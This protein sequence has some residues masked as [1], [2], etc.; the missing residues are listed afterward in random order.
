MGSFSTTTPAILRL[1]AWEEKERAANIAATGSPSPVPFRPLS[2]VAPY[3]HLGHDSQYGAGRRNGRTIRLIIL[4]TT[5]SDGFLNSM[6]Y[7]ARR[8]DQVSATCYSGK[9][10]ELGYTVSESDRPYTTKRWNDES[11][12]VEICGKAAYTTAQWRARPKQLASLTN[13]LFTWCQRWAV[14]AVWL[15][16]AEIAQGA[17]PH[18]ASPVQG[19]NYGIC[20]HLEANLAAILLGA[21]PKDYSH[22]DIGPGLRTIVINE[23]IPEVARRLGGSVPVPVPPDQPVSNPVPWESSMPARLIQCNDNDAAVFTTDGIHAT[24]SVSGELIDDGIGA[25]LLPPKVNGQLPIAKVNRRYLKALILLG[26]LPDYSQTPPSLP[27][28]TTAAHF[29]KHVP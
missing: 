11:I 18:G 14:P 27:G 13:L 29:K 23:I 9:D 6:S 10:G 26:P 20:D 7:G 22:V 24:S 4:H 2:P 21:A 28:R 19:V 15:W 16:K 3:T 12:T 1:E 5:E 17:S 8:P 25:G